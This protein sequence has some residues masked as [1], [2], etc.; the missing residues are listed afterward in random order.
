MD[1][2]LQDLAKMCN[3]YIEGWCVRPQPAALLAV[4]G[5]QLHRCRYS[6][7]GQP[8]VLEKGSQR[9]RDC[10]IQGHLHQRMGNQQV[11]APY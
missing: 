1:N 2:P 8:D 10:D 11:A 9:R 5:R 3:P 7:T 6:Q 4:A